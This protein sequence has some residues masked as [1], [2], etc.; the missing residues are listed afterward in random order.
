MPT[1]RFRMEGQDPFQTP[2]E[3]TIVPLLKEYER[4]TKLQ[5]HVESCIRE[6]L[7]PLLKSPMDFDP[8]TE[9]R[10]EKLFGDVYKEL[11]VKSPNRVKVRQEGYRNP[12]R[13]HL[14]LVKVRLEEGDSI[15][16]TIG[17]K[18][19]LLWEW[20]KN[21][22]FDI[23]GKENT[24]PYRVNKDLKELEDLYKEKEKRTLK[25]TEKIDA[26]GGMCSLNNKTD[27]NTILTL[28]AQYEI[29]DK[30]LDN[31]VNV[32]KD[33]ASFYEK[34]EEEDRVFNM[35]KDLH[36]SKIFDAL[37]S[38]VTNLP[39]NIR[40]SYENSSLKPEILKSMLSQ[41]ELEQ[42]GTS[43]IVTLC[44]PKGHGECMVI[45]KTTQGFVNMSVKRVEK[46]TSNSLTTLP[47]Y[48]DIGEIIKRIKDLA[49]I[50]ENLV[51]E[52]RIKNILRPLDDFTDRLLKKFKDKKDIS[53]KQKE[54][55]NLLY[56]SLKNITTIVTF[57]IANGVNFSHRVISDSIKIC[58][59]TLLKFS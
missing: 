26:P 21:A 30:Y 9:A 10:F 41:G 32:F 11:K 52:D 7:R 28:L 1:L 36:D 14:D 8:R 42:S 17:E 29:L 2:Y 24:S 16:E 33:F 15:F 57:F 48:S 38:F 6:P 23:I 50:Y 46:T 5:I 44:F 25:A 53:P 39:V 22:L 3:K 4:L 27:K 35:D 31:F 55:L 45:S 49:K 37:G 56:N 40:F 51:N 19:R 47:S 20:L 13:F 58:N 54:S 59:N 34:W 18:I 12:Y 43:G